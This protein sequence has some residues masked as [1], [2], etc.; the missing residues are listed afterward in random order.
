MKDL[1][2]HL[3]R[4]SPRFLESGRGLYNT[5]P[6]R[7]IDALPKCSD[8]FAHDQEY[9]YSIGPNQW[10]QADRDER[11]VEENHH[12]RAQLASSNCGQLKGYDPHE[13]AAIESFWNLRDAEG[14]NVPTVA[15]NL[16]R[17]SRLQVSGSIA[18]STPPKSESHGSRIVFS[19]NLA[20]MNYHLTVHHFVR[21]CT[22][23]CIISFT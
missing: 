6:L 20:V 18:S 11:L 22:C 23:M 9:S 5:P 1:L 12:L 8:C 10:K 4:V 16:Y 19:S 15:G 2:G 14:I 13:S 17:E 7:C 3:T 21:V